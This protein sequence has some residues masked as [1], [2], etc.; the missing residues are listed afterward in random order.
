MHTAKPKLSMLDLVAVREGSTVAQALALALRT[1]QHAEM[2][3]FTRYWLAEHHNMPGIASSATAVLVGHIAGGTQRIRVGSGGIMLPNH[4]PLVVAEAFGTLAEL[5]PDRIDLGLGR[6]PGTDPLTMRALR[7]NRVENEQ[8]FP[9]DVDELQALLGDTRA[10]QRMVANPGAG[11]HVP[12]WLLGS[13]LFSARLAA[14]RGL[15]YAFASHFAPQ[16][17]MQ[18]IEEY[19]RNFRP[20]ANLAQPY[21]AIGVPLVAA[22]TDEDAQFLASSVYQRVLGILS[23]E[24]KPLQAPVQNFASG[25]DERERSAIAEF[26]GMAVIG[27]PE[28]VRESFAAL[29]KMTQADE[30]ILVCDVFDPEWRLRSLS[31]AQQALN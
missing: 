26:L 19:R 22:P 8:D 30:F 14:E 5:Y 24:R 29:Q 12:I 21:I 25:L 20:S 28:R 4:A 7:R 11:T 16:M 18:A 23:G 3:G 15:P 1:A 2:L 27:G 9:R 31:I 10:G 17:M 6:A 13:S